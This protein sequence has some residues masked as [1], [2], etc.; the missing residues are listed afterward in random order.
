MACPLNPQCHGGRVQ[1]DLF[2]FQEANWKM[3]KDDNEHE[4][5]IKSWRD[6]AC[7]PADVDHMEDFLYHLLV[8]PN[9]PVLYLPND[10][11]RTKA[12]LFI[13]AHHR[14]IK[15]GACF[16]QFGCR[17]C[18]RQTQLLYYASDDDMHRS[19]AETQLL[20]FFEP[21]LEQYL[22]SRRVPYPSALTASNLDIMAN[23]P[24]HLERSCPPPPTTPPTTPAKRF[25]DSAAPSSKGTHGLNTLTMMAISGGTMMLPGSSS[26]MLN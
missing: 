9:F 26:L 17:Y 14:G 1:E 18:K 7:F 5:W 12:P 15:R 22:R 2:P 19:Y 20:T 6:R 23:R 21:L 24:A 4:G 16:V 10:E 8:W 25:R 13:V 11:N 3:V